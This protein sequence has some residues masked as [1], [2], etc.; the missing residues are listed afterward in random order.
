M[1][2]TYCTGWVREALQEVA[3]HHESEWFNV[4]EQ[5]SEALQDPLGGTLCADV[6]GGAETDTQTTLAEER[7][8]GRCAAMRANASHA[9][10]ERQATVELLLRECTGGR[11]VQ[12]PVGGCAVWRETRKYRRGLSIEHR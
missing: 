7:T 5:M 12:R 8:R 6:G 10:H 11:L 3:L 1:A 9:H 4:D 2:C